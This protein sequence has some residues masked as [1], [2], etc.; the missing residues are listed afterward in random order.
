MVKPL[1][2]SEW[3]GLFQTKAKELVPV[4]HGLADQVKQKGHKADVAF[5][6]RSFGISV[7]LKRP[8][9]ERTGT[10]SIVFLANPSTRTVQRV[11][12]VTPMHSPSQTGPDG[13]PVSLDELTA[14]YVTQHA[15]DVIKR[16][17]LS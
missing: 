1:S 5:D 13:P 16:S 10:P 6:S 14:G 4:L 2:E 7:Q 17:L 12:A 9:G 3:L 15:T 8:D 11:Q